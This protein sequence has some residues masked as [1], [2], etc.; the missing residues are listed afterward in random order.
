[1]RAV[2][3]VAAYRD[4][5]HITGEQVLGASA[6]VTTTEQRDQR[7]RAHVAAE[8]ARAI[9][10]AIGPQQVAAGTDVPLTVVK[11]VEL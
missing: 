8:R 9:A 3:T 1:M 4:R 11:G 6:E 5:W 2:S 10:I 7:R